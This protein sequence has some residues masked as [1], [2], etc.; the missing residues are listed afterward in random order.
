MGVSRNVSDY[1]EE[2]FD[3]VTPEIR[4]ETKVLIFVSSK[5]SDTDR[6][7]DIR[8]TWGKEALKAGMKVIFHLGQDVSMTKEDKEMLEEEIST[9]NDIL[10][11]SFVD[12]Y[13]NLTGNG[14]H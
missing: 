2:V 6:R 9:K 14:L 12:N 10:Q 11:Q 13:Q 3:I 4:N 8:S 1:L 5:F 7:H